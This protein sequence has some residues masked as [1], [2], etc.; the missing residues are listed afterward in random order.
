MR[1][2]KILIYKI[3]LSIFLLSSLYLSANELSIGSGIYDFTDPVARDFYKIAPSIFISY[4]LF[5][6]AGVSLN[7]SSGLIFN[8][9]KYNSKRHNL[10]I[11]P[12]S[13]DILSDITSGKY[14]FHPL[15]G[16]V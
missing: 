7:L 4:E 13:L 15:M 14:G 8:S 12:I 6:K 1:L 11:V 9:V 3:L 2:S 5:W 10:Y 16:L